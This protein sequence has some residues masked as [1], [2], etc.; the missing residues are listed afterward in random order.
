MTYNPPM[1]FTIDMVGLVVK[2]MQKSLEFYRVLGLDIPKYP[3]GEMYVDFKLPNGLRISWNDEK[4]MREIDPDYEEP[5]GQRIGIA[6]LCNSVSD[7]DERFHRVISA[8]YTGRKEPWD[9]F[10]GQRYAIVMDPDGNLVDL[11][12]PLEVS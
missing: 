7:V 8:G 9:A 3:D 2:D 1:S 6:F 4:M 5:V 12:H 10:W 11:F